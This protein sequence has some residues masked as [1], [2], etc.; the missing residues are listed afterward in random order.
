MKNNLAFIASLLLV[1]LQLSPCPAASVAE[2]RR[3]YLSGTDK[4]HTVPWDFRIDGGRSNGVWTSIA[5]PSCWE[6]QGFGTFRYGHEDKPFAALHANY[7]HRFTPPADWA[8]R[9]IF[10]VFDGVMTDCDAKLNG[11]STGPVHQGAFYRFKRDVTAALKP[12]QENLLEVA[13]SDKSTDESVNRAERYADFWVFG[14][15]FRPVWLEAQPAQFIERVAIDARA[16]GAF[17]LDFFLGQPAQAESIEVELLDPQGQ[18]V[19]APVSVTAGAKRATTNVA[20]PLTWTAETPRLYTAV[21]R[22]KQGATVLHE[23]KQRFGFRTIEVRERDGIYVNGQRVMLKGVCRHSSWPTTGR[24]LSEAVH[25]QDIALMKDMNMNAVRMSHYPPDEQFLDLCDELGLYVLDELT[26]W[27]KSYDTATARK[28]I[29]ELIARDVNHP[30]ILFWDNGNEG[31]W[32]TEVDGDFAQYDPQQRAVLHPWEK[33]GGINTKHYPKYNDLVKLLDSGD[34]VMP[35]E[36]LHGLYDGGHGAGLADYWELMLQHKNA[37]GGF[38][39]VLADEGVVR[40]DSNNVMDVRGNW[41]PDGIVGPYREKEASFYTI[42]QLWS[43]IEILERDL[44]VEGAFLLANR[45]SFT[46]ANQCRFTWQLRD[47]PKPQEAGAGYKVLAEGVAT[48]PHI[49]PGGR[50]KLQLALPTGWRKAHAL[51]LRVDDPTGRELWTWVWPTADLGTLKGGSMAKVTAA[52]TSDAIDVQNGDLKLRFSKQSGQL[53]SAVR[54]GQTFSLANGPRMLGGTAT[55]ASIKHHLTTNQVV[56][57]ASYTG[58]LQSV[59]W[60]IGMDGWVDLSY[61]YDLRGTNPCHG[62]GF[63]L[64]EASVK[65]MRWFGYGPYRVW[66]NRTAGGTLGVWTNTFNNTITGWAGWQ[67]PEFKGFYDGV[68]WLQLG[69]TAGP[70]TVESFWGTYVQVL[71]PELPPGK[72]P[73][74]SLVTCPD[75]GL[76]FLRAIPAIGSKFHT[77]RDTGPHGQPAV[78]EGGYCDTLRFYFGTLPE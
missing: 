55:L 43:P 67:Y 53:V 59:T 19:G 15:I 28:L 68:R 8:G 24:T 4:D 49:P 33:H 6:C 76:A 1:G 26:G 70:I 20:K 23:I 21:I 13:V 22:L 27:Q 29:P 37:C 78:S 64:P 45:Y 35:T 66:Q 44:N 41:A 47:F 74:K 9:R 11:V 32:N 34:L 7:S 65:D 48:A 73:A 2:T 56:I 36:F 50:G 77:A 25:R 60:T 52:E 61:R 46:D 63:D 57:T 17:A 10:L 62:V 38:L 42:K 72:L 5:V 58:N 54:R 71:K 69:T 39:W 31:G 16:D 18:P 40:C 30:S 14:G 3:L 51:A 75:A 12:G